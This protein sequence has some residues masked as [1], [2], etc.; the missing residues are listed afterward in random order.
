MAFRGPKSGASFNLNLTPLL[1]VVLQLITFFMMLIHF[2]TRLEGSTKAVRLP[3]TP[4]ALPSSDLAIDRLP[5]ALD[6][7]GRLLVDGVEREGKAAEAWWAEQA[8]RRLEGQ[9]TL[10]GPAG[11]LSTVVILRIDK[12][13]SYGAVR[14]VLAQAQERGF[15]HFSLVVQRS[16]EP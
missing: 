5:V 13:A 9:E 3:V 1:D 11:E 4:A 15:S 16:L 14:H 6:A 12:D 8:R 2:G 10:G 7:R